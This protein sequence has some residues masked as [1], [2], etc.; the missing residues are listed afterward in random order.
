MGAD[1]LVHRQ[2]FAGQHRFIHRG[3]SRQDGAVHWDAGA[4]FDDDDVFQPH[5]FGRDLHL[6]SVLEE[7]G[8]VRN[9]RNQ[10]IDCLLG[11]IF[12]VLLQ[13]LSK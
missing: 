3:F 9:H 7:D 8:G 12:A 4:G 13:I 1:L 10:R 5:I 6:L 11:G 2:A